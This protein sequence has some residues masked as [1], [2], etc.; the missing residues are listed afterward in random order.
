LQAGRLSGTT[1]TSQTNIC[2]FDDFQKNQGMLQ[3]G[4]L[5]AIEPI[6][7]PC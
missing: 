3:V 5:L 1:G 7:T 4:T 6:D 2:F